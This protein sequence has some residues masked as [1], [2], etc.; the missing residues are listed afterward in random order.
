MSSKYLRHTNPGYTYKLEIYTGKQFDTVNTTPTNVVMK[1]CQC[2]YHKRHTL[3]IDNWYT[4]VYLAENWL[5]KDTH[6]VGIIRK[7]RT[8][9]S[10]EVVNAKLKVVYTKCKQFFY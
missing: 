4:S 10:K 1:L 7:N 8:R 2:L 6:L 5:E 9:N 3:F